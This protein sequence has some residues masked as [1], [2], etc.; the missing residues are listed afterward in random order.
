MEE[1]NQTDAETYILPT[2]ELINL[3]YEK[4][5][6][7]WTENI[8]NQIKEKNITFVSLGD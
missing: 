7:I 1:H 3:V 5:Y 2:Q 4:L 8:E 6:E